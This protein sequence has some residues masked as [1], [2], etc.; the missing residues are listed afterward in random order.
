MKQNLTA[1][2]LKNTTHSS[3]TFNIIREKKDIF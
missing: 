3:D 2:A 1:D